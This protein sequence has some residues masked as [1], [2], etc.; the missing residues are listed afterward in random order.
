M[1]TNV[2]M[3]SKESRELYGVVIRQETKDSFLSLT[4][5]HEAYTHARVLNGWKDKDISN[6]M[7][8]E[9]NIERIFYLLKEQSLVGDK[10]TLTWFCENSRARGITKVLKELNCYKTT[11]RG[12]NKQ[13]M[14]NPYIWVLVAME[15]NPQLYA[16]VV[17]WLTDKLIFNRIEACDLNKALRTS[18]SRKIQSPDYPLINRTLNIK[19][20]GHHETGMRN[21]ASEEQ[22]RK[23]YRLEDNIAFCIDSGFCNTN[24]AI[25]TAISNAEVE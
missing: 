24:E 7:N 9:E 8:R 6:I 20:F 15:L 4:D 17:M 16:K 23:L 11:G 12:E 21:L 18:M 5:L 1:E 13:S 14:C 3:K 22:L 19:I 2:T 25:V 10:T